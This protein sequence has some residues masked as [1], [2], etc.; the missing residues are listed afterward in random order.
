[1]IVVLVIVLLLIAVVICVVGVL[2]LG[3][4]NTRHTKLDIVET[5][6][7]EVRH[8]KGILYQKKYYTVFFNTDINTAT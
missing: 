8:L 4:C 3:W 1:M 6:F 7:T 2:V 5:L